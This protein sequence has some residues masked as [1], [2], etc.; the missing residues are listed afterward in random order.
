MKLCPKCNGQGT[1]SKPPYIAGDIHQ[2]S[3]S[4]VIFNCDVCNGAKVLLVPAAPPDVEGQEEQVKRLEARIAALEAFIYE[5]IDDPAAEMHLK[6]SFIE[7]AKQLLNP[8]SP[9]A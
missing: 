9:S 7:A 3:S 4:S 1:V 2:W 8:Q 6:P 5:V